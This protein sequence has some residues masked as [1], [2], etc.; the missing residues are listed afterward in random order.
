MKIW[1]SLFAILIITFHLVGQNSGGFNYQA[2][3]RDANQNVVANQTVGIRIS[4]IQESASGPVVYQ[5]TFSPFSNDYGLINLEIGSGDAISGS[6]EAIDWGS[7]PYFMETAMDI[8]G[9]TNY[10]VM[11][12]SRLKSVPYALHAGKAESIIEKRYAIG[13]RALGGVVFYANDAGTHGLIAA[14]DDQQA[15]VN[16]ND[17]NDNL[18]NQSYHDEAGKAFLDW[19]IPTKYELNL[20]YERK[21]IIG[22]FTRANYWSSIDSRNR[23][24]AWS[25]NFGNGEQKMQ[26]KST[27]SSLRLIRTF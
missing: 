16:W 24:N 2:I 13:D 23:D 17:A 10:T 14:N 6:F 19:R 21:G 5:E 12:A 26:D 8:S 25:Q 4:I 1:A 7:G 27:E 9:G 20:M 15:N 22:N 3:V 18:N 11:G